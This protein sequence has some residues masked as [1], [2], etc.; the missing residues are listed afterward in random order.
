VLSL[1]SAW[2]SPKNC[3]WHY[4]VWNLRMHAVASYASLLMSPAAKCGS[5]P[6]FMRSSF[7]AAILRHMDNLTLWESTISG[8]EAFFP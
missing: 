6:M 7:S 8:Q 2:P 1:V 3:C 5:A 4:C